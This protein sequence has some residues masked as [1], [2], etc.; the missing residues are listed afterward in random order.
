LTKRIA[1]LAV[2]AATTA[3]IL[4]PAAPAQA[5]CISLFTTPVDCVKEVL[6]SSSPALQ[7]CV[8]YGT[9]ELVCLPSST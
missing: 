3:T 9:Y 4:L 7:D 6:Q 2:I 5:Y 8:Y 1:G